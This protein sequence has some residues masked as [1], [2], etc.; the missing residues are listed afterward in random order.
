M[1][2]LFALPPEL[3]NRKN[4]EIGLKITNLTQNIPSIR[5]FAWSFYSQNYSLEK[6]CEEFIS[7]MS[8]EILFRFVF[9][10]PCFSVCPFSSSN[11]LHI[12]NAQQRNIQSA[13]VLDQF[14][15]SFHKITRL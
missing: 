6:R 3:G 15:F 7:R 8:D 1:N 4:I 12:T 9:V 11:Y 13:S 2:F 10:L 5:H 14:N